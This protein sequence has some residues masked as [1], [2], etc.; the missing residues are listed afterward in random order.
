MDLK[1]I[2]RQDYQ[3]AVRLL[4]G[5]PDELRKGLKTNERVPL[6]I[7]NLTKEIAS[8][9][10]HIRPQR[11]KIKQIVYDLTNTFI[12]NVKRQADE[13]H[14]SDIAKTAILEKEQARLD[15]EATVAGKSQGEW[16][17]MGIQAVDR[18]G[19]TNDSGPETAD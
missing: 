8:L 19:G 13:K 17:E 6:F 9:P 4:P 3:E 7:D 16:E 11:L 12:L 18:N 5:I 15:L 14:L 2:V 1:T 10:A